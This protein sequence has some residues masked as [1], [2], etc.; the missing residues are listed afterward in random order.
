MTVST[1][2]PN[3]DNYYV[4]KGIVTFKPDGSSVWYDVGNVTELEF[5]PSTDTLEHF[6]SREGVKSK[7]LTIVLSK[8]GELRMVMEEWTPRNLAM[9]L[10]GDVDL[11]DPTQPVIEIFSR[12]SVS[13]ELKFTGTN[14]QGPR[15]NFHFLKVDFLP[16]G[17]INPISA[18]F[19][20]L[21]VTGQVAVS[22][23]SF[24][25]V[26][27]K[28]LAG[29]SAPENIALPYI[30]S[31]DAV[32]NVGDVLTGHVGTWVGDPTYTYTWEAD[33]TPIVGATGITYTPVTGD[34]GSAITFLAHATNTTGGPVVAESAPTADVV[35]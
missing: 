23:G 19:G 31:P 11:S 13:G 26:T 35:A 30:T 10:V 7:D 4:G 6:S 32:I 15:Y 17:S 34:I 2:S 25:T 24:G 28:N 5:T 22:G 16:S 1:Q 33:G 9:I 29:P 8:G 20:T 3:V 27:L 21:E 18:E 14:S 12:G